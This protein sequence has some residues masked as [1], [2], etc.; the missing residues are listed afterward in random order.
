ERLPRPL[1]RD[2]KAL[3]G[4][5]LAEFVQVL[6][7]SLPD[8]NP[9]IETLAQRYTPESLAR[10]SWSLF[11]QWL[12]AEGPPK[13]KWAHHVLGRFPDDGNARAL[14]RLARYWAPSGNPTRAQEAVEVLAQM[15]T[16]QGLIEIHEIATQVQ[17]KALRAR[18]ETVFETVAES[19]GIG[20]TEL[21][22]RLIP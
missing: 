17:S 21:A 18:A 3:A 7:A 11:R 4:D 9:I 1:T 5:G 14:G 19:L 16:Q 20:T 12:F 6:K 13:D 10:L 15:R 2:G 8:G 22:D